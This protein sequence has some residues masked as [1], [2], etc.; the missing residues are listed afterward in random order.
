MTI[1]AF[2]KLFGLLLM[3][4]LAKIMPLD[5]YGVFVYTRNLILMLGPILTLGFNI[6]ALRFIPAYLANGR[7]EHAKGFYLGAMAVTL[8]CSLL[9]A[10]AFSLVLTTSPDMVEPNLRRALLIGV[11]GLAGYAIAVLNA[12]TARALG[13]VSV[14]YGPTNLGQPVLILA[15]VG[16]LWTV[17]DTIDGEIAAGALVVS[18]AVIAVIQ[19]GLIRLFSPRALRDAVPRFAMRE[20]MVVSPPLTLSTAAISFVDLGSFAIL[21]AYEDTATMGVFGLILVLVQSLFIVNWSLFGI[22]APR[23]SAAIAK[24]ERREAERILRMVRLSAGAIAL[25]ASAAVVAVFSV[26]APL[27]L[28]DIPIP[29]PTLAI[30]LAGFVT[31]ALAGPAGVVLVAAGK[32]A[33]LVGAQIVSAVITLLASVWLIPKFGL[34][35]AATA[36]LGGAIARACLVGGLV[37]L[38]HGFRV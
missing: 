20:W 33:E 6:S 14:A 26:G 37:H 7:P 35:G 19:I 38:R 5:D 27:L 8:S 2:G 10:A 11:V 24:N 1:M 16:V 30:A 4:M 23:I 28:P 22:G 36:A 29:L 32:Q 18:Y 25:A 34:N 12:V 9:G 17:A 13:F 31:T 21:G 15:V 3:F